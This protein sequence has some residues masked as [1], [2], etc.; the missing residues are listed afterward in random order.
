VL[1][2]LSL[3]ANE[4]VERMRGLLRATASFRR[5]I[6][7]D[8]DGAEQAKVNLE[9]SLR[10]I[11]AVRATNPTLKGLGGSATHRPESGGS[12]Y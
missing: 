10:V 1:D 3:G 6:A 4:P 2:L 11:G 9:L 7:A 8:E 12:G 5:A